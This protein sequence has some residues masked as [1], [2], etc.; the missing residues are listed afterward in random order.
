MV[1]LQGKAVVVAV[2]WLDCWLEK[3]VPFLVS[4]MCI[5]L[6]EAPVTRFIFSAVAL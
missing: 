4:M 1:V 6:L 3:A 5:E 2:R